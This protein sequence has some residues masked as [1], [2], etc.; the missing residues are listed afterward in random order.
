MICCI[1][2]IAH[3]TAAA[4]FA[5]AFATSCSVSSTVRHGISETCTAPLIS[6]PPFFTTAAVS[7]GV[8]A[9]LHLVAEL[10]GQ[11]EARRVAALHPELGWAPTETTRI[12]DDHFATSDWPVGLNYLEPWFRPIIGIALRDGVG[13]LDA[14]AA[15][16]VYSQS[17]A[18]H[19]VPIALGDTVRTRHGLVLLTTSTM[20]AALLQHQSS[21]AVQ[22]DDRRRLRD[23]AG[24]RHVGEAGG[25]R[26][27]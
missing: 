4:A 24:Q 7:S 14:T 12:P 2:R 22:R 19:T 8:P 10:A 17:G 13:E 26:R 20:L 5:A 9:A 23:R 1:V 18:A 6:P 27:V 21:R 25:R 3:Q 16:E 11:A 15:F